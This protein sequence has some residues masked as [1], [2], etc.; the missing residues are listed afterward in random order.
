MTSLLIARHGNTFEPGDKV[1]RVGMKTDLPLSTSG[2]IQAQQLGHFIKKQKIKI[3]AV[4]AGSLV[5]TYETATLALNAADIQL[6]IETDLIFNEIDYGIDEGKTDE[7]VIDRIGKT[8]LNA[9]NKKAIVPL[10]WKAHPE[11]IIK[12]W[13]K[14][15]QTIYNKYPDQTILVV[16]S[17]G[18]AR[19]SPHITNDFHNFADNNNIKLSTGA[20]ASIVCKNKQWQI[21]YWN[22]CPG[23]Y[24]K[25]S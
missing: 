22:L 10:G 24:C 12:T 21:N 25:A 5:R 8:A 20:L 1:V 11:K 3:S 16:T 17:N 4:F 7:E 13:K 18:I 2:K 23:D 6:D 14:F 19:F 9:W 15:A